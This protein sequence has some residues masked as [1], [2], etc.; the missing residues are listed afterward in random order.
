MKIRYRT[1]VKLLSIIYFVVREILYT[2]NLVVREI[3]YTQKD[4]P[5]T[6]VTL[7]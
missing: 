5:Q 7:I 2:H 6:H 4:I 3:L 1:K